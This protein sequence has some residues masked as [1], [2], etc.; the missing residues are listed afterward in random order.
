MAAIQ[1]I[2]NLCS[3]KG[4]S[5]QGFFRSRD[6]TIRATDMDCVRQSDYVDGKEEDVNIFRKKLVVELLKHRPK[7]QFENH[8]SQKP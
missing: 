8:A 6:A 7:K 1:Y 3:S 5:Q 4:T 2:T